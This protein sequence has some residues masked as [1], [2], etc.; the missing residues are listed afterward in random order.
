LLHRKLVR[1]C[2]CCIDVAY[3]WSVTVSIIGNAPEVGGFLL[4]LSIRNI[5]TYILFLFFV[6]RLK[7]IHASMHAWLHA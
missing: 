1:S 6:F 7:S 3:V 4:W 5:E 2:R